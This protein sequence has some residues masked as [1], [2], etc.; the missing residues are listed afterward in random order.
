MSEVDA[1]YV[2]LPNHAHHE[3]VIAAA[4][5]GKAILS[6]KSLTTSMETAAELAT[7]VERHNVFFVEGLMYLA[8]PLYQRVTDVLND[9][10]LGT[11]RA[12]NGFYAADIWQVVNPRGGGT[13][14][15]LGC[16][17]VS[18]TH[19]VMQTVFGADAFAQRQSSGAGNSTNESGNI[20]DAAIS[21]R[22]DNGVLANLQSSD[23]YGMAHGFSVSGDRGVL[24]FDDQSV[25]TPCRPERLELEAV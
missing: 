17:P 15:N 24:E 10:R 21:I 23:S 6:E 14:F 18:L 20:A 25:A 1:V 4:G 12:I 9:G 3:A 13:I 2:G 16:Y 8:H 19:L 22:F 5:A 7:A 11:V